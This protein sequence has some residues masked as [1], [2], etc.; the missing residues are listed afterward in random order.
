VSEFG[1]G[2]LVSEP[3]AF[4]RAFVPRDQL[5][6]WEDL[7]FV[8]RPKLK[9]LIDG[10]VSMGGRNTQLEPKLQLHRQFEPTRLIRT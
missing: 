5:D 8:S 3:M 1:G 4:G 6:E 7:E 2:V 9:A 10:V